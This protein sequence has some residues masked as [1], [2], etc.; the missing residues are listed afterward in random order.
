MTRKLDKEHLDSIQELRTGFSEIASYI[1][2]VS[3]EKQLLKRQ[4]EQL[5]EQETQ[6]LARFDK[7]RNDESSLLEKLKERYGDGEINIAAG[8]FTPV[9]Q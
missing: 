6:L 4:L 5:A 1:G 8:T 3:I 2:N 9:G 7:L